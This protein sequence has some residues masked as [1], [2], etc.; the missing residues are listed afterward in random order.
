MA[1]ADACIPAS[2]ERTCIDTL[3]LGHDAGVHYVVDVNYFP[4]Y[5]SV[6]NA[7]AMLSQAL[8]QAHGQ[9]MSARA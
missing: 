4:S 2:H 5:K 8:L 9:H 7:P 3:L 6:D 1:W